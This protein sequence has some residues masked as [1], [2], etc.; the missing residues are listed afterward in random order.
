M[1]RQYDFVLGMG[2]TCHCSQALREAGLQLTSLPFDWVGGPELR[3]KAEFMVA[4]FPGWFEAGTLTQ[5]DSPYTTART[6]AWSDKWGFTP[7]HDFHRG[8]PF[9]EE[10][11]KVMA[12]YRRRIDRMFRLLDASERVLV[13][14]IESPG[15]PTT[16][17]DEMKEARRLLGGRWPRARFDFLCLKESEGRSLGDAEES[18]DDGIRIVSCDYRESGGKGKVWV[19]DVKAL[20]RWFAG[21]YSVRDYRTDEERKSWRRKARQTKYAAL[22][23]SGL[24]D[25]MLTKWRYKLYRHLHKKLSKKGLV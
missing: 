25:Y 13:V 22:N 6:T 8:T 24:V 5:I 2:T 1:T 14:Y 12:K 21:E 7:V 4:G 15:F 3:K 11:P 17:I 9:D 10:R 18:E 20:A 16:S 19:G 23:A